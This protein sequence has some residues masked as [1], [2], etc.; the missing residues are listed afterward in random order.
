M[1]F[2][3]I[4]V[5]YRQ[6]ILAPWGTALAGLLPSWLMALGPA[7]VAHNGMSLLSWVTAVCPSH[8]TVPLLAAPTAVPHD[9]MSM[10]D[11]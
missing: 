5:L 10:A 1:T 11:V 9:G 7:N 8:T 6:Q 4:S 3:A 2:S